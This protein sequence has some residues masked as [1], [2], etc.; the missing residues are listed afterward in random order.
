MICLQV[1]VDSAKGA[2][3]I[4]P[5]PLPSRNKIS[6]K[7]M[8]RLQTAASASEVSDS[9]MDDQRRIRPPKVSKTKPIDYESDSSDEEDVRR[10]VRRPVRGHKN[11]RRK[12]VLLKLQ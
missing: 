4:K 7:Q 8:R 1:H 9:D 5:K 3:V 2:A 10:A 11:G 12:K 6:K